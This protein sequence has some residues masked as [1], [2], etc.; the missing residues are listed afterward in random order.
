MDKGKLM[1]LVWIEREHGEARYKVSFKVQCSRF[2]P[3]SIFPTLN[4]EL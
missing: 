2:N 3:Q 4:I 1:I